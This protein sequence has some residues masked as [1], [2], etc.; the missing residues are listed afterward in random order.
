MLVGF[1]HVIILSINAVTMLSPS[2]PNSGAISIHT[3]IWLWGE[4][5][6][7]YVPL[8]KTSQKFVVRAQHCLIGNAWENNSPDNQNALYRWLGHFGSFYT[9]PLSSNSLIL[10]YFLLSTIWP[11]ILRRCIGCVSADKILCSVTLHIS[12]SFSSFFWWI[13]RCTVL[14]HV[15]FLFFFLVT[16]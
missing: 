6:C 8:Y 3:S 2:S 14:S 4:P 9:F 7:W 11:S 15:L 13:V 1:S 10:L 16:L 5:L 12:I